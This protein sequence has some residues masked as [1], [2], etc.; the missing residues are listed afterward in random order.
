MNS[1]CTELKQEGL[2]LAQQKKDFEE[3]ILQKRADSEERRFEEQCRDKTLATAV[4]L[5]LAL[6]TSTSRVSNLELDLEQA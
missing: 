4:D 2:E 3:Q 6:E 1:E 5:E